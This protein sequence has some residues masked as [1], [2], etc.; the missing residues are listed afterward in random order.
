LLWTT[1][2]MG[3]TGDQPTHTSGKTDLAAMARGVGVSSI[4]EVGLEDIEI[5]LGHARKNKGPHI[6]VI[7]VASGSPALNPI[8]LS[9]VYIRDRFMR[10]LKG[11]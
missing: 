9:L 8:P 2:L 1:A 3:P 5:A 6:I 10:E 11:L 7:R 4:I